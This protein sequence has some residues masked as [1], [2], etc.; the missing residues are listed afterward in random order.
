V[1]RHG[2]VGFWLRVAWAVIYPV[3]SMLFKVRWRG[4]EHMPATGGVLVV[5]NHISYA[6]PLAFARYVWDCGR[7]PRFLAKDS[8]FRIFFV[9]RVLS[10]AKQIPVHRGS[11]DAQDSLR[12]AVAALERGEAVCIYPE[13]TVTR[14]PDWWP[15]FARTGVARLA[16]AADVPVVPVGQWGAQ[17]AVD[18]YHKK[19]RLLPRKQVFCQAGPP[20][21]LSA[22]RGRPV[23]L[24]LL[25]E[26][27][28]VIMRDVRALVG[29]LR[30]ETPPVEFWRPARVPRPETPAAA[31]L[32]AEAAA[33]PPADAPV[34]AAP[35]DAAP[36]DAAPVD[37]APVDAAA[38][39]GSDAKAA[40]HEAAS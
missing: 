4:K 29:E 15:M 5:A 23:T 37:A 28:D 40:G 11:A 7:V 31:E 25:R 39:E 32:A 12:D 22:Y 2:R 26:V 1:A 33:E 38:G 19:F 18:V 9:G 17:H 16:L 13:G 30:G 6:D 8:L 34:D 27:T 36:V 20:V 21:D 24:E 10:G 3:D 35:V 14:D